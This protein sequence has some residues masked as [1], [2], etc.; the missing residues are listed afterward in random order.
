MTKILLSFIFILGFMGCTS[1]EG[2]VDY[3]NQSLP[4][5]TPVIFAPGI[6]SIKGRF[7]HGISFTPDTRQLAFGTLNPSDFGGSV[8]YSEKISGK[9]TPPEIFQPLESKSV[10]LPYFTPDGESLL[11]AQSIADTNNLYMTDIWRIKQENGNWG[12]P[13]KMQLPIN[14]TSREAN[15]SMTYGGSL[16]FSSNRNCQGKENC[17][18]ADLFYSTKEGNSYQ[19]ANAISELNSSN[20][21]ESVFISPKEDY[22]LFCRYTDDD[23]F[24][25]LHISY[26]DYRK[27]WTPAVV[28]D[29]PINSKDWDR[30]PF[31][32][33]DNKLLFFTRLQIG[34]KGLTESDI[35]WANT[36]KVFKPFVFRPLEDITVPLGEKFSLTLPSDYFKDVDSDQLVLGCNQDQFDWLTFDSKNMT[37][38][39]V[40]AVEGDFKLTFTAV[41]EF[42]NRTEDSISI[43]VTK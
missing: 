26:R 28:L 12:I 7:E 43:S 25:D 27:Q 11:Y 34:E 40:P 13:K 5:A 38:S 8:F 32:S 30:R 33:I 22:I 31:V 9:W 39:G 6:V 15:A 14:S 37:L 24:V 10:F 4:D 2:T 1:Q 29:A 3:L 21:E 17:Y 18:T 42:M 36:S 16:Y 35:Y 20:D 41:D 19:S 23:S